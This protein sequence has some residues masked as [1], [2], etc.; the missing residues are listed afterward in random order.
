M[1]S[2]FD[3]LSANEKVLLPK[4]VQCT[5]PRALKVLEHILVALLAGAPCRVFR[6]GMARPTD[7]V[8]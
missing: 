6:P 4:Y 3:R 7:E 1:R 2:V 8:V 5:S